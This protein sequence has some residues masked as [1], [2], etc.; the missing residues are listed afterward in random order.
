VGGVAALTFIAAAS[1]AWRSA[2]RANIDD[3]ARP[4][5]VPARRLDEA[6]RD[7]VPLGIASVLAALY[8]RVDV[9]L[10][11][12]WHG[13]EAAG[14]YNAV[15]RIVEA[16]RLLP[17]AVLAVAM[18]VLFRAVDARAVVRVASSLT[19]LAA[20]VSVA[21]WLVADWI[22][23]WTFGGAYSPAVPAFRVLLLGFPLMALNYALTHQLI[24]W[25]RHG[26][27][28]AL[29][30]AALAVNLAVNS[31]LIPQLSLLGAAWATVATEGVLTSGCLAVL[32]SH[33]AAQ[34]RTLSPQVQPS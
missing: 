6:V 12:A 15:F 18:P 34:R 19:A 14:L 8:F 16:L 32:L 1:A 21:L 10:L 5:A 20:A 28:A 31:R 2:P 24:G 29:C 30:A 9:L 26:A 22:V 23:P 7:I 25:N 17:A 27:Y 11:E 33:R 13:T 3:E 4:V